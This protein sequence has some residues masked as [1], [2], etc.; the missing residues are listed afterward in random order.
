MPTALGPL[1]LRAAFHFSAMTSKA[2]SQVTGVKSPS[3]W[4]R[5][6]RMRS[7]GWV[8]RSRP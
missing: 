2:R 5:P 1:A 8:S 4:K 6:P 7:R 3:L